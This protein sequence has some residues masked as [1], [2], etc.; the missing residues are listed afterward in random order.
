M[1]LARWKESHSGKHILG[2]EHNQ[3]IRSAKFRFG[4][5]EQCNQKH[6][7]WEELKGVVILFKPAHQKQSKGKLRYKHFPEGMTAGF[8]I[9]EYQGQEGNR[10]YIQKKARCKH[11]VQNVAHGLL[12]SV[13]I[14][15]NNFGFTHFQSKNE[16]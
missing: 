13:P 5:E 4:A 2:H 12:K 6:P 15:N 11:H 16:H 10:K 14:C 1:Q 3:F 7:R 9:L 8:K